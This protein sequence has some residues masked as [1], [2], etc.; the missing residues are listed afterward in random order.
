MRR[1]I[2]RKILRTL[3]GIAAPRV[4]RKVFQRLAP[5]SPVG[6]VY[7]T[8]SAQDLPHIRHLYP[9][10]SPAEFEQDLQYLKANFTL[11]GY[12]DLLAHHRGEQPLPANAAYLSFDD[13]FAE[14]WTVIRPILARYGV[15]ATFFLVT[16]FVDN[17]H[18]YYRNQISLC[19]DRIGR[20][21][22]PEQAAM[23]REINQALGTSL[24]TL[25]AF[26]GWLKSHKQESSE[27]V[28]QV[29][30]LLGVD[31]EGFLRTRKPFLSLEQVRTLH[32]EGHT[33]GAHSRQH[34]KLMFL[35]ETE[36]REEIVASCRLV[37]AWVGAEQVPF[38]FPFSGHA[39]SREMLADVRARNPEVGLLFDTKKLQDDRP[40]IFQRVMV[41]EP[42]PGVPP[43][44][45]LG[46]YLHLAHRQYWMEKW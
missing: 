43:A 24:D 42:L 26:T 21:A 23:L 22:P 7:H 12:E 46:R 38:A 16:D 37:A 18:L 6:F 31:V 32:A 17:Q 27:T 5:R 14:C 30:R 11:V 13:G 3:A 33:I 9:Y 1:K 45:N 35:P 40:F 4:P 8:V 15:R 44:E 19:I 34:H 29:C 10:K 20:A 36:Q 25:A 2:T 39:V 41:D 28:G